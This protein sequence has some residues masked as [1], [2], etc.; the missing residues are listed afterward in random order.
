MWKLLS[1][2]RLYVCNDFEMGCLY[3]YNDV[4]VKYL[5]ILK[6]CIERYVLVEIMFFGKV[7]EFNFIF[8]VFG[9]E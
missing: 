5:L 8:S 9:I 2:N 3:L 4:C 1:N 6:N 7:Y